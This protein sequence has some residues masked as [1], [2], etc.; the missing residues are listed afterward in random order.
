M[1]SPKSTRSSPGSQKQT[2]TK[3]YPKDSEHPLILTI[4]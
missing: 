2:H 4:Q 1:L 3:Q